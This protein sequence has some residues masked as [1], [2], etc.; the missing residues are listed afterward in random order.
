MSN[1]EKPEDPR[2]AQADEDPARTADASAAF[3]DALARQDAQHYVLR[4]YVA[5]TTP[6]SRR[7]VAS[8]RKVCEEELAG[9]YDLEVIDIYQEPE[10]AHGDQI[11]A[12]PTLVKE[13]PS[14]LRKLIGDLSDRE[15]VLVGLNVRAKD[16]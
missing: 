13:L 2:Q 11:I 10:R 3:E 9:R 8:I 15:R 12:A 16:A 5:G 14:P 7:A 4:L 6:Q 1:L